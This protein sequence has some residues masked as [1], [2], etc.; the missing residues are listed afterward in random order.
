MP[1]GARRR[2]ALTCVS[3]LFPDPG[4][5]SQTHFDRSGGRVQQKA[6]EPAASW[7]N[8]ANRLNAAIQAES[9]WA[10]ARPRIERIPGSRSPRAHNTGENPFGFTEATPAHVPCRRATFPGLPQT[11]Q[12]VAE[13]KIAR[14]G[15]HARDRNRPTQ[16]WFDRAWSIE[17][18]LKQAHR[19]ATRADGRPMSPS[20][21]WET[22]T[23][24]PQ[25]A[26][27]HQSHRPALVPITWTAR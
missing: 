23:P 17:S 1:G 20:R 15:N 4:C 11:S 25:R 7:S 14:W 16:A 19:T 10:P 5:R 26:W 24:R 18:H 8:S 2:Y 13:Q 22:I 9:S 21:A 6:A 27:Q 3:R 12:A